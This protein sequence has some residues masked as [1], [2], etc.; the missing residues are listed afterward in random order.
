MSQD[1]GEFR[2]RPGKG[3]DAG[4]A[5]GRKA[6]SLAA[7]VR[8]A[9]AKSGA[10]RRAPLRRS[11]GTGARGRGRAVALRARFHTNGRRVVIK[12]R[13]V[14]HTGARFRAAPLGRHVAYLKRDGVTRDGQ[15][16]ELFDAS[17]DSVDGDAFAERSSDDRHHFRFIVSPEDAADLD[18][19]RTFTRE[20]MDDVAKDLGTDLEWVAVDHWNTDNPHVHILVRGR[21]DDG[22]DLVIDKDYIREGMRFR[23]EERATLELGPRSAREIGAALDREVDA[24][25]WTSLDRRLQEMADEGGGVVDLRPGAGEGDAGRRRLLGRAAKLDRMGLADNVGP[26]VWAL[27]PDIEHTL[28]DIGDRSDIIRTM[29]RAMSNTLGSPDPSRFAVHDGVTADPV[30]GRLVERGLHD[31]LAGSAYAVVDGSDGRVHHLRF[32]DIDMTGDS[33]PGSIVE[34]RRWTDRS[35]AARMSLSIRSDLT[36]SEQIRAKGATWVDRQLVSREVVGSS[37]FGR[38]I[39]E[40]MEKRA[41]RLVSDGLAHRQGRRLVLSDNLIDTLRAREL[42]DTVAEIERSTGLQ[43]RPSES[44]D[45]VSGVYRERINLSSGRFAMIDDGLGFQL[46]PWRPALDGQIGRQINGVMN[47]GGSVQWTLG[48]GK[49]LSV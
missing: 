29:H 7:Q 38:E 23:A 41:D 9:S 47:P 40:A 14:R 36:L 19:L 34:L 18:D 2:P 22:S 17:A 28:R 4:R 45:H 44:G 39:R 43:H 1:D 31:E 30:V 13:V 3:R 8:R 5:S 15:H 26:A 49:G 10:T 24:D 42:A 25:R 35:G 37:G 11:K 21:V 32:D 48:R 27:K 6:Q 33:K 20:L 46:V 12:A 16:A